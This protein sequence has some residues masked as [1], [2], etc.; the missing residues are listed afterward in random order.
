MGTIA[1]TIFAIA[2]VMVC[3]WIWA[4]LENRYA[5]KFELLVMA[6]DAAQKREHH[7]VAVLEKKLSDAR[8]QQSQQETYFAERL[9][10]AN[11]RQRLLETKLATMR[12][13]APAS[14]DRV[15]AAERAAGVYDPRMDD[16]IASERPAIEVNETWVSP[17]ELDGIPLSSRPTL[18]GMHDIAGMRE[19]QT[20][21]SAS[22][23][24]IAV[25]S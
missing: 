1:A 19:R 15:V 8:L 4:G 7:N 18:T 12:S 14:L 17:D 3:A 5:G 13:I 6:L 20:M 25:P 11:E 16:W 2:C 21:P 10:A 22:F 23:D 24:S 9:A